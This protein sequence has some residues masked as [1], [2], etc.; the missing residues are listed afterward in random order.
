MQI[1]I[2]EKALG[3]LVQPALKNISKSYNE[4]F[5]TLSRTH[6]GRPKKEIEREIR[7]IFK[8]HGGSIDNQKAA[9]YAQ[10]ISEGKQVT[11]KP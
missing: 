2:N 5:A 9:S 3:R 11:F 10:L 4:E 8:K 7:R 1:N 6:K